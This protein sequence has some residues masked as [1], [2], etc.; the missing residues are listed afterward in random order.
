MK[1]N[2]I[3]FPTDLSKTSTAALGWATV[4]ARDTGATLVIVH[5]E[6]PPVAYGGGELYYGM[7]VGDREKLQQALAGVRPA[8]PGV[9]FVHKLLVG[10]PARAIVQTAKDE[11]ADLIVMG[12]HGRTGLLRVLM[13]SV[14]EMVVREA[15]CPVL[16][17]RQPAK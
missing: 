1:A 15:Q 6:E 14:A 17:V 4:L 5:V 12:T 3:V 7:D 9:K 13:G 11:Q 10:N 2:K 8:D 16:T